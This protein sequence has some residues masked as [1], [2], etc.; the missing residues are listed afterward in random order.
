MEPGTHHKSGNADILYSLGNTSVSKAVFNITTLT[1][2]T[3]FLHFVFVMY[4]F[5]FKTR[6]S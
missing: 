2:K 1:S 3:F 4:F 6:K 5:L